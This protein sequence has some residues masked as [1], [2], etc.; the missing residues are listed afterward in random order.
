[1]GRRLIYT[2][3]ALL[4]Q[5]PE[6]SCRLFYYY[7]RQRRS[8]AAPLIFCPGRRVAL[9]SYVISSFTRILVN[10]VKSWL[11]VQ[12]SSVQC[13]PFPVLW[14]PVE[15]FLRCL[16]LYLCQGDFQFTCTAA[17]E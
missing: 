12:F 13:C 3:T 16:F 8:A 11:A 2:T 1:M 6:E 17:A 10:K 4:S 9:G 5:T 14:V 7:S 15:R